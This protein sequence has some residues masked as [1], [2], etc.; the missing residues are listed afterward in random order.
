MTSARRIRKALRELDGAIERGEAMPTREAIAVFRSAAAWLEAR[1]GG[2]RGQ[3]YL[4]RPDRPGLWWA[5]RQG[6]ALSA[7]M[8]MDGWA[9][10]EIEHDDGALRWQLAGTQRGPVDLQT[11][12]YDQWTPVAPPA[13][14][15][16]D[17]DCPG[18]SRGP[19]PSGS[20]KSEE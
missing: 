17:C 3:Y 9:L 20:G 12:P 1:L 8:Q 4:S 5:R 6:D 19:D 16:V 15:A 11:C 7:P 14:V 13:P 10:L 2:D 18:D